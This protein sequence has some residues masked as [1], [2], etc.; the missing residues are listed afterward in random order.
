M[1]RFTLL[2]LAPSPGT[3]APAAGPFIRLDHAH[4]F[5]QDDIPVLGE[6]TR[7]GETVLGEASSDDPAGLRLQVNLDDRPADELGPLGAMTLQTCLLPGRE[8][9]YLLALE[10]ARHRV[11]HLF[12]KLEDWALFVPG[13]NGD[14]LER[15]ESARALFIRALVCQRDS[16]G[17][18]R[19]EAEA[20][21]RSALAAAV[22]A[23]ERLAIAAASRDAPERVAGRMYVAAAARFKHAHGDE[24][25]PG[26]PILTPT[27]RGVVLPERPQVGV[28]V[29]PRAFGE[30]LA[31][32]VQQCA[33]FVSI[34]MRWNDME[35]AEGE[36]S[37]RATDRWIEWAVRSAKLPVHAG[38]VIDFRPECVPEWLYIWENDYETLRELVYEH[39]R[40]I[41]T[42][43]RRTVRRWTIASGLHVNR[44]IRLSFDQMM[45]L[46]RV[47]VLMVKKLH[48]QAK[49]QME[50]VQPFGGYYAKNRNSLPP[51]L[52]AD[53]VVQGGLAVDAFGIKLQVGSL[54]PGQTVRDLMQLSALLDRF[55][56]YERPI[57]VTIGCP[58]AQ[59]APDPSS[60]KPA[61][62]PGVWREAWSPDR[63]AEWLR[64]MATACLSKPYV[65]SVTWHQLADGPGRTMEMPGGGLLDE[66]GQ[67]RPALAALADIRRAVRE[68]RSPVASP[69]VPAG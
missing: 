61:A 44:N 55:A 43:Y 7:D 6:V 35:P 16:R 12:H 15:V 9:P 24:P 10:L 60:D 17:L 11:M 18:F 23:G 53:M 26:I 49:V 63:Q 67:A 13:E 66:R 39:V 41:V 57:A 22:D 19:P 50:I 21:A 52:Y 28:A 29:D 8:R 14:T 47:A 33:D 51:T 48:P 45:D 65:T 59:I 3:P 37:F 64:R 1:L 4:L 20:L 25:P 30:P 38:P 27:A 32:A 56:D 54:Q 58:S 42:R 34:P 31:N 36:L 5:G 69:P 46:T 62:E 2:A 40:Q 68:G